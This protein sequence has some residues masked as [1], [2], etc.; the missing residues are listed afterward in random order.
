MERQVVAGAPFSAV[1]VTEISQALANGNAIQ[2]RSQTKVYRDG[3]GRVRTEIERNESGAN[4]AQTTRTIIQIYDPVAG[5]IRTIDPQNKTAREMPLRS[6]PGHG[7]GAGAA[8]AVRGGGPPPGRGRGA[9]ASRANAPTTRDPNLAAEALSMQTIGGVQAT[10][11]RLTHTIPAGQIG[12][13]QP[14]QIVHETWTSIDLKVPVMIKQSDPRTGTT[15]TQLTNINRSEPDPAL[16]QVPP[17]YTVSRNPGPGRGPR[18][19]PR[20]GQFQ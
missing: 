15:T 6:G 11:S 2:R 16:F 14:I 4:G 5:V 19:G 7:P 18:G 1:E 13:S 17:D 3:M 12:N 20:G 8:P 10:G 9:D